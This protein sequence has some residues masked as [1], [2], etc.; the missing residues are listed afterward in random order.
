MLEKRWWCSIWVMVARSSWDCRNSATRMPRLC[1]YENSDV[2]IS[3]MAW[4]ESREDVGQLCPLALS[5]ATLPHRG[6]GPGCGGDKRSGCGDMMGAQDLGTL[7]RTWLGL[8][9][10]LCWWRQ[11]VSRSPGFALWQGLPPSCGEWIMVVTPNSHHAQGISHRWYQEAGNEL[12]GDITMAAVPASVWVVRSRR[13]CLPHTSCLLRSSA[14]SCSRMPNST[15]CGQQGL[16]HRMYLPDAHL[17]V[18]LEPAWMAELPLMA[19]HSGAA[20]LACP[21]SVP[22]PTSLLAVETSPGKCPG[23]RERAWVSSGKGQQAPEVEWG[24]C[25]TELPGVAGGRWWWWRGKEPR[26][27]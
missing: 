3:K 19:R 27:G 25:P 5:A 4:G 1:W 15:T 21:A 7:D 23:H 8:S 13:P 22:S 20:E 11:V 6:P 12:A 2:R 14:G 16:N 9:A 18:G 10:Q 24:P 26:E 17:L